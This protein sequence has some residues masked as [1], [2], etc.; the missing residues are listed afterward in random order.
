MITEKL[1]AIGCDNAAVMTNL[2]NSIKSETVFSNTIVSATRVADLA[3]ISK[4]LS[5]D[6]IIL[7]FENNQNALND[8]ITSVKKPE[9]PVLCL[10]KRNESEMLYWDKSSIVFTFPEENIQK[11]DHLQIQIQ[12]VFLLKSHAPLQRKS[13]VRN[14]SVISQHS[15][16]RNLSRYVMEL[17]QKI[18][19]LLKVKERITH[20]YPQVDDPIRIELNSIVNSIKASVNDTKV[21]EDFKLYFEKTHPD[22]L[23]TL[24]KKHPEL[25]TKDLK[26]CCYLKMNMTNDDIRNLLGINQESVRTHKF[27][28][29]RKMALP[30]DLDLANYLRSVA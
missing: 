25:T 24:S 21:W 2:L 20:L 13:S 15:E 10:T 28:L 27:R 17:D 6:L 29:K 19:T 3:G 26:Y 8:L 4:T 23:L 12:S 22:F 30:K 16:N 1:I 14:P 11:K 5:P 18:E 7:C 9:I